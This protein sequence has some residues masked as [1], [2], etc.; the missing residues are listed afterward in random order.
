MDAIKAKQAFD[1]LGAA[2]SDTPAT[3]DPEGAWYDPT[4]EQKAAFA[5]AHGI[6]GKDIDGWDGVEPNTAQMKIEAL[7][8]DAP[9]AD[10]LE[11][12]AH[13]WARDGRRKVWRKFD[14]AQARSTCRLLTLASADEAE[15]LLPGCTIVGSATAK[16]L[17][18]LAAATP[19]AFYGPLGQNPSPDAASR[20]AIGTL[21][22][23]VSGA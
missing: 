10:V 7:P 19:Q 2:L 8:D 3:V 4:D 5:A 13:G 20:Y 12:A 22:P 23:F 11:Y 21:T 6:A 15:R 16:V 14:L 17:V 1:L 9:V 18:M